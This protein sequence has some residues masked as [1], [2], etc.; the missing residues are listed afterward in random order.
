MRGC[1][2][3]H[4]NVAIPIGNNVVDGSSMVAIDMMNNIKLV[5]DSDFPSP[6]SLEFRELPVLI[7]LDAFALPPPF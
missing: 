7:S 4:V 1:V 5:F 6:T 2:V 3:C